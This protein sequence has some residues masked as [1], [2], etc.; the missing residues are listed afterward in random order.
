MTVKTHPEQE[1]TRPRTIVRCVIAVMT[2]ITITATASAAAVRNS[3]TRPSGH[4]EATT[5]I[6]LSAKP[7]VEPS[8]STDGLDKLSADGRYS[9]AIVDLDTG[10][11][12]T[13]GGGSFDTASIVKVDILAA[14]LYQLQQKGAELTS[15]QDHLVKAM[16]ERSDNPS[17]TTLFRQIGG[18]AAL[19]NFNSTIGLTETKIGANGNWGLTQTTAKDQ[20][21]LL[22]TVFGPD[23]LLTVKSQ[24]YIRDLM[25]NVIDSQ[26]FGVSA[27]SKDAAL[28]VGYLQRS[29][30][31]LWDVASIGFARAA[32]RAFLVAF[33]SDNN[34]TL[35]DGIALANQ[36]VSAAADGF[37]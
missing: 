24:E 26:K 37:R 32:G 31:G 3:E 19:E 14:L 25:A 23:S 30:T 4:S 11:S 7:L 10:E 22:R 9:V 6:S 13:Y 28:K 27:I 1:S 20:L 35:Q 18:K 29:T 36:A 34:P 2:A 12:L 15:S 16:I 21:I 5:S 8:I 33:L 17:A